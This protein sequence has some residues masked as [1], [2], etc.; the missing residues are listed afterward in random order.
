[1]GIAS[2]K[3]LQL[4]WCSLVLRDILSV[5]WSESAVR[6]GGPKWVSK[7]RCADGKVPLSLSWPK[8]GCCCGR[9]RL[10]PWC[11]VTQSRFII[12][13]NLSQQVEV[14]HADALFVSL[15][16]YAPCWPRS[17]PATCGTLSLGGRDSTCGDNP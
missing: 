13:R 8:Y 16:V 2:L 9:L 1:M 5:L 7:E 10:A 15:P 17:M 3:V 4:S 12:R 11:L 6:G 14:V